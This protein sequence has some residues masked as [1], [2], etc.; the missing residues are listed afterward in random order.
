MKKTIKVVSSILSLILCVGVFTG[1]YEDELSFLY[2]KMDEFE[3]ECNDYSLIQSEEELNSEHYYQITFEGYSNGELLIYSDGEFLLDE[4]N[5]KIEYQDMF[6]GFKLSYRNQELNINSQFMGT[7]SETYYNIHKIW[8]GWVNKNNQESEP[9][10]IVS[11]VIGIVVYDNEIFIII[12]HENVVLIKREFGNI[13]LH[14]YK[15]N[16]LTNELFY[17]GY[18]KKPTKQSKYSKY[19]YIVKNK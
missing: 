4:E 8:N 11:D 7:Y 17:C 6:N 14:M 1:C 12:W 10:F 16:I 5:L 15:F 3:I 13:P 9:N 18:L 19:K 2:E